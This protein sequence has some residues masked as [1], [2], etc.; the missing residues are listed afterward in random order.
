MKSVSRRITEKSIKKQCTKYMNDHYEEVIYLAIAENAH[1]IAEQVEAMLLLTLA[2]QHG[3]GKHRLNEVHSEF[4][5]MLRMP[6]VFGKQPKAKECIDLLQQ[7]YGIDF[8]EVKP[9]FMSY[10]EYIRES[11]EA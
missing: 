7:K 6:M 11:K 3:F 9:N 4:C 2:K 8:N 1:Y 10:E 5:G